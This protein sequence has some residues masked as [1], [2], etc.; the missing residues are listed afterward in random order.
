MGQIQKLL[1]TFYPRL[2]QKNISR[3]CPFNVVALEH[4]VIVT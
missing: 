2:S 3:Y 4:N 1:D